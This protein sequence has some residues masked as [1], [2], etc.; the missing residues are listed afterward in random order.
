LSW[1]F[2]VPVRVKGVKG[3]HD[4]EGAGVLIFG[5]LRIASDCFDFVR[6]SCGQEFLLV[7]V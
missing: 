4:L 5:L 3:L 6:G 2:M 1:L 7:V